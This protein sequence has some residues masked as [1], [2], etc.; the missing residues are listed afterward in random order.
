MVHFG[1]LEATWPKIT[2]AKTVEVNICCHSNAQMQPV[3]LWLAL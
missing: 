2:A 3:I 1:L